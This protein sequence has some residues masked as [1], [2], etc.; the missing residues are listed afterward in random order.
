MKGQKFRLEEK[1]LRASVVPSSSVALD[2]Y[3]CPRVVSTRADPSAPITAECPAGWEKP[4]H[5]G[6]K[7]TPSLCW[8]EGTLPVKQQPTDAPRG[9]GLH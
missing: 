4:Q 7:S 2:R 8:G 1:N 6:E 3:M 5:S 9:I